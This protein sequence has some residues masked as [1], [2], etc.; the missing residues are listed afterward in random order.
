[1]LRSVRRCMAAVGVSTDDG[2]PIIAHT[3]LN[4]VRL[5]SEQLL[6]GRW[7]C[8]C[9]GLATRM[10]GWQVLSCIVAMPSHKLYRATQMLVNEVRCKRYSAFCNRPILDSHKK[11]ASLVLCPPLACST[12]ATLS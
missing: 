5:C 9:S 4:R 10:H 2:S 7:L 12:T 8:L 3:G 6:K 11:A 1:M